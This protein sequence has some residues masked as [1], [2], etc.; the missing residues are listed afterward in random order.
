VLTTHGD[1]DKDEYAQMNRAYPFL[2]RDITVDYYHFGSGKFSDP[3]YSIS[4]GFERAIYIWRRPKPGDYWQH[5]VTGYWLANWNVY[6]LDGLLTE[7]Y[8]N[9]GYWASRAVLESQFSW[10]PYED[11]LKAQPEREDLTLGDYDQIL[12]YTSIRTSEMLSGYEF[13]AWRLGTA[14]SYRTLSLRELANWSHVDERLLDGLGWVDKGT[15]YDLRRMPT[16]KVEFAGIPFDILAP[17][18]NGGRSVV[19]LQNLAEAAGGWPGAHR[20]VNIPVGSAV[21]SLV[22]L[23]ATMEEGGPPPRYEAIFEDGGFAPIPVVYTGWNGGGKLRAATLRGAWPA[24]LGEAPCGDPVMLYAFE[25]VNPYPE[26]AVKEVCVRF[27][28]PEGQRFSEALFAVTALGATPTD[29]REWATR[30]DRPPVLTLARAGLDK[31]PLAGERLVYGQSFEFPHGLP[32]V[33]TAAGLPDVKAVSARAFN[34][35]DGAY[36]TATSDGF[37]IPVFDAWSDAF[38]KWSGRFPARTGGAFEVLLSKPIQASGFTVI[39]ES[40]YHLELQVSAD[41]KQWKTM[42][43]GWGSEQTGAQGIVFPAPETVVAFRIAL[44]NHQP[45]SE[46]KLYHFGFHQ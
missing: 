11:L 7:F 23:R 37:V 6:T 25:W 1:K 10:N 40:Y 43:Q 27:A 13:P 44:K 15:N 38:K 41:G 2:A 5:E 19:L 34:P 39:A 36:S 26:K 20:R 31:L 24:W 45:V 18:D 9:S 21:G 17:A 29:V 16:G 22:F 33:K 30:P 28:G 3:F 4:S 35:A 12:G 46:A 8:G 14:G 42:G 32:I